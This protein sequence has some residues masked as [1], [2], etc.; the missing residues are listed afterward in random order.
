M[1]EG[2][3]RERLNR[4]IDLINVLPQ[5]PLISQMVEINSSTEPQVNNAIQKFIDDNDKR[6]TNSHKDELADTKPEEFM[7]ANAFANVFNARKK[8]Q[9]GGK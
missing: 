9:K 5:I 8:L 3:E 6:I 1:I 2:Y 4:Q 7:K